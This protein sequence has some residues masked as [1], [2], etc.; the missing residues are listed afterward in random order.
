[1][2]DM[3]NEE[4]K[5]AAEEAAKNT[6][7]A[8]DFL[9]N[10]SQSNI[11]SYDADALAKIEELLNVSGANLPA[12]QRDLVLTKVAAQKEKLA[13]LE[14]QAAHETTETPT[15]EQP[16]QTETPNA[17]APAEETV[18]SQED[19]DKFNAMTSYDLAQEHQRLSEL[20]DRYIQA[21]DRA[22][23]GPA[24]IDM[25]EAKESA[26]KLDNISQQLKK[27]EAY[28]KQELSDTDLSYQN[29]ENGD[30]ELLPHNAPTVKD[31]VAI[32]TGAD[33]NYKYANQATLDAALIEYDRN[34]GFDAE[35]PKAKE[36]EEN[37]KKWQQLVPA[38][39]KILPKDFENNSGLAV[40]KAT[41][42]T[43]LNE[44]IETLRITALTELAA[45]TPDKDAEAAKKRYYQKY[46][47]IA[48]EYIK[49]ADTT[50]AGIANDPE[51]KNK[52]WQEY[53]K[54]NKL[55]LDNLETLQK[56]AQH[57]AKFT[58]FVTSKVY[59]TLNAT[60]A[61]KNAVYASRLA[62][63]TGMKNA[64]ETAAQNKKSFWQKHPQLMQTVKT[65]GKTAAVKIG[66]TLG[67]GI[68][69]A[70]A[71]QA[72]QMS[73]E[74]K[75]AIKNTKE[76]NGGKFSPKLL[77][78]HFKKNPEAAIN[79]AK[80]S[81]L[82]ATAGIATAALVASG[83]ATFGLVGGI[84][85]LAATN[86][87]GGVAIKGLKMAVSSGITAVTG[88]ATWAITRKKL[89][90]KKKELMAIL[91]QHL[92]NGQEP[93]KKGFL[94]RFK[95]NND[96]A[97]KAY[98]ELTK[99]WKNGD[100]N[101]SAKVAS[102]GLSPEQ[103]EQVKALAQE[104]RG[105]KIKATTIVASTAIGSAA[106]AY[107]MD[108]ANSAPTTPSADNSA[109]G[110][111]AG[112]KIG[113]AINQGQD[114]ADIADT[115]AQTHTFDITDSRVTTQANATYVILKQM[116]L[117]EGKDFDDLRGG[118]THI[119]KSG[120]TS[121]LSK[122]QLTDAQQAEFQAK[123]DSG[124]FDRIADKLKS[125][126]MIIRPGGEVVERDH[127]WTRPQHSAGHNHNDNGAE[128][129]Q[130][131]PQVDAS[132]LKGAKLTPDQA[133]IDPQAKIQ[134]PETIQA[135]GKAKTSGL[136]SFLHKK[137]DFDVTITRTGNLNADVENYAYG[138]ALKQQLAKAGVADVNNPS[139]EQL[140]AA[141]QTLEQKGYHI[142][143]K[144]TDANGQ[145]HKFKV[146]RHKDGTINR[147]VDGQKMS[148]KTAPNSEVQYATYKHVKLAPN[149]VVDPQAG[150]NYVS[151]KADK[152]RGILKTKENGVD[153][154]Y[155]A[156]T[157]GDSGKD[158]IVKAQNGQSV[159]REVSNGS[160]V[161]KQL[162]KGSQQQGR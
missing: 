13:L 34:N 61:Q 38:N 121:Y 74:F 17:E 140:A 101:L 118:N 28:A 39:E 16:T 62:Q 145:E 2:A 132:Q 113:A 56:D 86:A 41:D 48:A 9:H 81:L 51:Q 96:P 54:A 162:A 4:F 95:R 161:L 124:E 43:T 97:T 11:D 144:I 65:G 58:A 18:L 69:G 120:M 159:T 84:A 103:A 15:K 110:L 108:N 114:G 153:T 8:T 139:A 6:Q 155:S 14:Q 44:I 10:V 126:H 3:T 94:D 137:H 130:T 22:G 76:E 98:N 156:V 104:I 42:K 40:L 5:L 75:K 29:P 19:L 67:F 151:Q 147:T 79:V 106:T 123:L 138:V 129:A 78:L 160:N 112:A 23:I 77:A 46:A 70:T 85:G 27:I 149:A 116:G 73:N 91:Q 66:A 143:G 158:F 115:A 102:L 134:M 93:A 30:I 89:N 152:L 57:Q 37:E 59:Q 63:K 80:S 31:Y 53:A 83:A 142:T 92:G 20:R 7:S 32:L 122:L 148:M 55:P 109:D 105:L 72:W 25:P 21:L 50:F 125:G 100:K 127:G 141:K 52:W 128:N 1:M 135:T 87:A 119:V 82:F 35:L 36:I 71:A 64:L 26:E 133:Q 99:M 33:K 146:V 24:M 90:P 107:M 12:S 150:E 131:K 49:T 45:E 60:Y 117:M 136:F 154:T 88:A 47:E 68:I 157:D 111:A